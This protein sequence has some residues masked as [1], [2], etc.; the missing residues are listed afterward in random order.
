MFGAGLP[1]QWGEPGPLLLL[2]ALRLSRPSL[3]ALAVHYPCLDELV[4]DGENGRV[5]RS[6]TDLARELAALFGGF[7]GGPSA[8]AL[9]TLSRGAADT[10]AVRWEGNWTAHAA[11]LFASLSARS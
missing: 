8:T 9:E 11:P 5:F 2:A 7:P 10:F 1:G 4:R 6:S 3:A